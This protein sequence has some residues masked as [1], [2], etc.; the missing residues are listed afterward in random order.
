MTRSYSVNE[1]EFKN[2]NF[3]ST[4]IFKGKQQLQQIRV[5]KSNSQTL[6]LD[7]L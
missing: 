2:L 4:F 1:K 6:R 7:E 3:T 5:D